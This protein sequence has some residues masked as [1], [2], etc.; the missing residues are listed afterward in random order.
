MEN[1][2]T[3][4]AG[5]AKHKGCRDGEYVPGR[6]ISMPKGNGGG[7]RYLKPRVIECM[8]CTRERIAQREAEEAA[9]NEA[10]RLYRE[11]RNAAFY[12]AQAAQKA[13]AK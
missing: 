13:E 9:K 10:A 11:A 4:A 8:R 12:A 3:G 1:G 6:T 2:T 5:T 7:S